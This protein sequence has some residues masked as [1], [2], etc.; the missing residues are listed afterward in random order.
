MR[1]QKREPPPSH[2]SCDFLNGPNFIE[3]PANLYLSPYCKVSF[4]TEII[5][6]VGSRMRR[7]QARS[8]RQPPPEGVIGA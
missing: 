1:E 2:L 5:M 3:N 7:I 8:D 6:A 4:I